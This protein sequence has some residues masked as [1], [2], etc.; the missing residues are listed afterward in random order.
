EDLTGQ[1]LYKKGKLEIIVV[2]SGSGQ[3]EEAIVKKFQQKYDNIKYIKTEE[4]ETIYKAWNRAIKAASGKYITNAN[5]DDRHAPHMLERLAV[6]LERNED[7]A[8]VYSHFYV[9]TVENQTWETKTPERMSDWHPPYS[10]EALLKG[11]FMGPQPMWRKSLHD[12]YGYFD[13]TLKVSGDYEFFLRVS[14]THNFL[15]IPEPLGLYLF[16]PNSLERTAGTRDEEDE[17]IW[18]L[19][20]NNKHK[21]ICRPFR[22]DDPTF[23]IQT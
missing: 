6:E 16:S 17:R 14:Q 10:R 7:I 9:T 3:D 4:R 21:I 15:L 18:N 22:P 5:T 23:S 1:S 20:R 12:E 13:Q 2:N 19:Y 8:A 11:N